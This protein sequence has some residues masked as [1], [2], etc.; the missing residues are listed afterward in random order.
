MADVFVGHYALGL[1]AKR[2]EPR[3]SLGIL[4]AAP[5]VLD[6]LWPIFV[7]AGIEHV[8]IAPGDT[9]FTPLAF[10]SYPWSHSLVASLAWA[11]LTV[12]I[13]RRF[14]PGSWRPPAIAGA[15]VV[16]HWVLDVVSHRPD[17]PLWPGSPRLGLGL[18]RSVPAT[19]A[20]ETALYVAGAALYLTATRPADRRGRWLPWAL[21]ALL[22]ALYL[23][24]VL[25][26]PPPS[27]RAVAAA[28]LA[29]WL[30]PP[31]G[32]WIERH[33]VAPSAVGAAR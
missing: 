12:W 13:V 25:G 3:L 2:F 19:L 20:V 7:L 29:L 1:A 31:I 16:S 23:G 6:L 9:A 26:P 15:L 22:F 10:T 24:T 28:A 11:T 21:L 30:I 8:E 17:M 33:R 14:T 5:Q 32:F 27:S 18:W 4:L